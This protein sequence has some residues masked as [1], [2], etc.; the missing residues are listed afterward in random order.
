MQFGGTPKQGIRR[1]NRQLML[2]SELSVE[3]YPHGLMM[4]NDPPT[5]NIS[6][7]DFELFAFERVKV[8]HYL[9]SLAISVVKNS[10]AYKDKL[11]EFL[12]KNYPGFLKT[13]VVGTE[14]SGAE[15]E[16]RKRDHVSH[17]ILR[18][19]Y[20]RSEE[21][22][23]W[24][25]EKELDLF[26]FRFLREGNSSIQEFLQINKLFYTPISE[27]EKTRFASSLSKISIEMNEAAIEKSCY[28]R[29]PFEEVLN[30]VSNRRVFLF[31][32]DAFVPQ[33][34]FL[35]IVST[36]FREH[37]SKALTLTAR[38][39]PHLEEDDRLLPILRSFNQNAL[40]TAYDPKRNE[41]NVSISDLDEL[42]SVSYPLC[43]RELHRS[44]K[45]S[46][47]LRHWG[48]MQYGLFLKGI[49]VTLEDSLKFWRQE[50]GKGIGI[51]KFD[52]EHAYNI[53]HNYGK[54]GKRTNYTPY[55][56]MTIITKNPPAAQ[57]HHG[58][59]FKHT[60]PD[61]LR[62]KLRS[63]KASSDVIEQI[64]ELVKGQHFQIACQKY[65]EA[66]HK[67]E[68]ASFQVTHPNHYFD[69]SQRILRGEQPG[70]SKSSREIADAAFTPAWSVPLPKSENVVSQN[71]KND[72]D[73]TELDQML[74]EYSEQIK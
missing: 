39:L 13:T 10:A 31:E 65:F 33:K 25:L 19:A 60:S 2:N 67:V 4:Y 32:G 52:K 68:D 40:S 20:C 46:H 51:D 42:S 28:Y 29:V 70:R 22:R 57:D 8:L 47:H 43:M 74:L 5:M 41:G 11:T 45:D 21:L 64:V 24:F 6:L 7:Q 34:E 38:S 69:E 48:R 36:Q 23:R 50:M 49:G 58:C 56:C 26:K 72:L 44:L 66:T 14:V 55:S 53:R 18:L 59:P 16:W 61:L 17:F 27:K 12:R 9:D 30:L 73:D 35:S 63:Y 62:Q 71:P 15:L 3:S 1:R 37:L 54:E